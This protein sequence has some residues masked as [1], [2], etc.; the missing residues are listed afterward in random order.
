MVEIYFSAVEKRIIK[1]SLKNK[2]DL[3][4]LDACDHII[5]F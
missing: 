2:T 4:L 3:K 1:F 5:G